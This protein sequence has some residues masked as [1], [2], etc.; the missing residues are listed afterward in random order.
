VFFFGLY[1]VGQVSYVSEI[2]LYVHYN[3]EVYQATQKRPGVPRQ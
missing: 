3:T 2:S 1:E